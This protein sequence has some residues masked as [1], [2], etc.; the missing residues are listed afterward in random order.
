MVTNRQFAKHKVFNVSYHIVWIP[1]YRKHILKN[2]IRGRLIYYLKRKCNDLHIKLEEFEIMEDHV[3]LFIKSIPT[4]AISYLVNQ[5][6]GY[7]SFHIRNEFP[8]L[9][10][11]KSLWTHSYFCETIGFIS[12][13]TIKRYIQNQRN[14]MA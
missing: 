4:L 3:H 8:S 14:K 11:Y 10:K 7:T 1:K 9:K 5:L 6:K 12:E 2:K 13:S